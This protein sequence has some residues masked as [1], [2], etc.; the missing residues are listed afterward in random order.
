MQKN[1]TFLD[2]PGEWNSEIVLANCVMAFS[3]SSISLEGLPFLLLPAALPVL[4][5]LLE[6][7]SDVLLTRYPASLG[8]TTGDV[9]GADGTVVIADG[10]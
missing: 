2:D 9:G 1:I 5:L 3:T 8:F 7:V 10:V 6:L 4:L